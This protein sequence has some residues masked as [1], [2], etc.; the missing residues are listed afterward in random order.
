MMHRIV[1][2]RDANGKVWNYDIQA[3]VLFMWLSVGNA[4]TLEYALDL[5]GKLEGGTKSVVPNHGQ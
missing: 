5:V 3:K 2:E 1:E 4:G